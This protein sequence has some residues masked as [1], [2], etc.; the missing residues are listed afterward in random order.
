MRAMRR[1]LVLSW[2]RALGTAQRRVSPDDPRSLPPGLFEHLM[3]FFVRKPDQ[4]ADKMH[5][6]A[7]RYLELLAHSPG[8]RR[9][10]AS[11]V[12]TFD[13]KGIVPPTLRN[14]H[15]QR[16]LRHIWFS[17]ATRD[18]D[19]SYMA[20]TLHPLI[21]SGSIRAVQGLLGQG[22]GA[23]R[24]VVVAHQFWF[25]AS[26]DPHGRIGFVFKSLDPQVID[27]NDIAPNLIRTYS[28]GGTISG[29]RPPERVPPTKL[30]VVFDASISLSSVQQ[31]AIPRFWTKYFRVQQRPSV[32]FHVPP[33][34][35]TEHPGRTPEQVHAAPSIPLL[36]QQPPTSA[37]LLFAPREGAAAAPRAVTLSPT[38]Q[39]LA[40]YRALTQE[41]LN[42]H[43][44][45]P[46]LHAMS[47][48][49]SPRTVTTIRTMSTSE[50]RERVDKVTVVW[51][52]ALGRPPPP[53]PQKIPPPSLLRSYIYRM[54]RGDSDIADSHLSMYASVVE[55]NRMMRYMV[56]RDMILFDNTYINNELH[57]VLELPAAK[58]DLRAF[59]RLLPAPGGRFLMFTIRN[60]MLSHKVSEDIRT[61][62]L[63]GRGAVRM[64]IIDANRA[65]TYTKT[66]RAAEGSIVNLHDIPVRTAGFAAPGPQGHPS[67]SHILG[68][69][70]PRMGPPYSNR[71]QI[72]RLARLH[73]KE[74]Q[75]RTGELIGPWQYYKRS[76]FG[77][78]QP[79][80]PSS[81]AGTTS[82]STMSTT[83]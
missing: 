16:Y 56:E 13:F 46:Q 11:G 60:D 45:P 65:G 69:G 24:R 38:E 1:G 64:W 18:R 36:P 22:D 40:P 62:I 50:L 3:L 23:P 66:G 51:N 26:Q 5:A 42:R 55:K 30:F 32:T 31:G 82:T 68:L 63:M 9:V 59:Q 8:M 20:L 15:F 17:Q 29:V 79:P 39:S 12:I 57:R 67:V 61:G 10:V 77:Q 58:R 78:L 21:H 53:A 27:P 44:Y 47:Y 48:D 83:L 74:E 37:P 75:V 14:P 19:S 54:A 33:S 81:V 70:N 28:Q 49:P 7:R 6:L 71:E 80:S 76:D 34:R 73:T 41:E 35:V 72:Y 25:V 2:N 52:R 43:I 4:W